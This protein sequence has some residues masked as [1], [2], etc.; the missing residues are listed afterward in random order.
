[1]VAIAS[2]GADG[3]K[4]VV[5]SPFIYLPIQE[6]SPATAIRNYGNVGPEFFLLENN[7]ARAWDN[8]P[9][10]SLERLYNEGNFVRPPVYN[11]FRYVAS[12]TGDGISHTTTP[13]VWP[14][15]IDD[16]VVDA[17][18][19]W[20]CKALE[21]GNGAVH[22]SGSNTA[23]SGLDGDDPADFIHPNDAKY[24]VQGD[25]LFDMFNFWG[26]SPR[27]G[28][29]GVGKR[30]FIRFRMRTHA[31][32]DQNENNPGVI[33]VYQ[34]SGGVITF[35]D[36]AGD[37]PSW[38]LTVNSDNLY[39]GLN[40]VDRID[41]PPP[42]GRGNSGVAHRDL[43]GGLLTC[44]NDWHDVSIYFDAR[45]GN[46]RSWVDGVEAEIDPDNKAYVIS[47]IRGFAPD[48]AAGP[49]Y[50][51]ESDDFTN[52]VTLMSRSDSATP[53]TRGAHNITTG[54]TSGTCNEFFAMNVDDD[55][56]IGD[57]AIAFSKTPRN[58]LPS[59]LAARF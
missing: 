45:E 15:V 21:E 54:A 17:G 24:D 28:V 3:Y 14:V 43:T 30:L 36:A 41:M 29:L 31:M 23:N 22:G 9:V 20:T 8:E 19:T 38:A 33:N 55:T 50:I 35:G 10:Y 27:F 12:I 16:T 11:G 51:S 52:G 39:T 1:M 48:A 44:D 25:P 32:F 57:L 56:Y 42:Y 18:V 53:G 7:T 6:E 46:L 59:I 26:P 4:D 47:V 58:S 5:K 13:P 49:I 34:M 2:L 40:Y 37:S